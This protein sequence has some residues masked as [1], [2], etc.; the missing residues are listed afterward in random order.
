MILNQE[1]A[2]L[3]LFILFSYLRHDVRSPHFLN[4]TPIHGTTWP[5]RSPSAAPESSP[6][7]TET[8]VIPSG[9]RLILKLARS[10]LALSFIM[11]MP[12]CPTEDDAC[13]AGK[14]EPLS[15]MVRYRTSVSY[16]TFTSIC[17][18]EA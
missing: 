8:S 14:P 17:D 13:L 7:L 15:Q 4:Y 12:K 5:P 10:F 18:G 1:H 2:D 9:R 3:L 16:L 6:S 11:A